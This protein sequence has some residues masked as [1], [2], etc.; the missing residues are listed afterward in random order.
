MFVRLASQDGQAQVDS[1]ARLEIDQVREG[2]PIAVS[3]R[4][5]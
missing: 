4:G 1:F 5:D 2:A 3:G